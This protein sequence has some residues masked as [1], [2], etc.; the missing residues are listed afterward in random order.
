MHSYE[1]R[2]IEILKILR[3]SDA[4]SNFIQSHLSKTHTTLYM[5]PAEG[6][7]VSALASSVGLYQITPSI[8]FFLQFL[9]SSNDVMF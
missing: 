7:N 3:H 1:Q 5:S 2:L 6:D 4:A 9:T 8:H